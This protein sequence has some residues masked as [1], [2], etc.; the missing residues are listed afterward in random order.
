MQKFRLIFQTVVSLANW[1]WLFP[2]S[3]TIAIEQRRQQIILDEAEA[4]R[5]DR[6]RNP[7]KYRGK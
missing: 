7:S 3:V 2:R 5:L 4:D 1:V 6:L